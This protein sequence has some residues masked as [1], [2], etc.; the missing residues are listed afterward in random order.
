[1]RHTDSLFPG[2][3]VVYR[4][5]AH[6]TRLWPAAEGRAPEAPLFLAAVSPL[7]LLALAV[8]WATSSP[9]R[10][11]CGLAVVVALAAVAAVVL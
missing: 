3:H 9:G 1:M 6:F 10:F 8:L 7:R 2:V 4:H 11:L 5:N